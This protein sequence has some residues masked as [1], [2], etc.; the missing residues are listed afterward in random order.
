MITT[1]KYFAY[2]A[3]FSIIPNLILKYFSDIQSDK[4]IKIIN[5]KKD[6]KIKTRKYN[7]NLH[8]IFVCGCKDQKTRKE[9]P[10][11][12]WWPGPEHKQRNESTR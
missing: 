7:Y 12:K 2:C 4:K 6:K 1:L 11:T 3:Q 10:S 8:H 9:K 5:Y